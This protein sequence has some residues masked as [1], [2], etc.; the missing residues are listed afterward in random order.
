[1]M[2][3]PQPPPA[4]AD[5]VDETLRNDRRVDP[6]RLRADLG[7]TPA[8]PTYREGYDHCLRV[9]AAAI[10]VTLRERGVRA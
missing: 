3:L 4:A 2:H 5:E 7:I 10:D 9:D 6:T 8:Y 1:M